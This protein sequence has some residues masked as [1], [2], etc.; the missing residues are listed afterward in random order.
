MNQ[1][2][3]LLSNGATNNVTVISITA[4][5]PFTYGEFDL[6]HNEAFSPCLVRLAITATRY[7]PF[8]KRRQR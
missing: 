3:G 6:Y 1:V 8:Q 4:E 7:S 5:V 2:A